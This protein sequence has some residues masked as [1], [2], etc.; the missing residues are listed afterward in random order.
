MTFDQSMHQMSFQPMTR[1]EYGKIMRRFR[2]AILRS[3][4]FGLF[5]LPLHVAGATS[6]GAM[7][8][9]N[10]AFA[11]LAGAV[12]SMLIISVMGMVIAWGKRPRR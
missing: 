9:F 7:E 4:A 8:P 2:K 12:S 5:L 10:I 11:L 6:R 3:L 1:R